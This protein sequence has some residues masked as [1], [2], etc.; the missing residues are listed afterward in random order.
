MAPA[1]KKM[2]NSRKESAAAGKH[3]AMNTPLSSCR[4]SFAAL[5]RRAGTALLALLGGALLAP[6]A[7]AFPPAPTF[8]V[9]GIARNSFGFALKSSDA[10]T[11]ILRRNGV[12]IGQADVNEQARPGENF[13]IQLPMDLSASDPYRPGA[14]SPGVAFTVELRFPSGPQAVVFLPTAGGAFPALSVGQPG[15]R[16]FLD[17]ALGEDLDGDGIPDA[18]EYYMLTQ[19]GVGPGDSLWS[20]NTFGRGSYLGD[21]I[22]DFDKFRAGLSPFAYA[23]PRLTV[24]QVLPDGS[25]RLRASVVIDKTYRIES[26]VDLRVWNVESIQFIGGSNSFSWFTAPDSMDL[27]LW[28]PP[29]VDPTRRY[30]RLTLL[31]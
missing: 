20:L 30:F 11:V 2:R 21:G 4:P 6:S 23:G 18:W 12:L 24:E 9:H 7:R 22:S 1:A 26:S 25:A 29:P 5:A 8:T 3:M 13:R 10:A 31:R 17:F 14:Q 28:V 27:G 15:A 16:L 19:M